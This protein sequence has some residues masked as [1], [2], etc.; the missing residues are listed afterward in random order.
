MKSFELI[1]SLAVFR[2]MTPAEILAHP[3]WRLPLTWQES[4]S[5]LR[6]DA[7]APAEAIWLNVRFEKEE[8]A[9]G[10]VPSPEFP[11]LSALFPI[12]DQVPQAIILAV[13]EKEV[14]PLFQA[15]ENTMRREFAVVGLREEGAPAEST[16]FR[17]TDGDGEDRASFALS[18]TPALV[19]DLGRLDFLDAGHDSI[20]AMRVKGEMVFAEFDLTDA[21]IAALKVGDHLLLPEL[22][23]DTPGAFCPDDQLRVDRVRVAAS[24]PVELAFADIVA[25]AEG[26][27]SAPVDDLT[28]AL[29]ARRIAS[30]RR[31]TLGEQP[32]LAIEEVL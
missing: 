11:D 29:G 9:L 6:S 13:I 32:A 28:L 30:G 31:V 8:C 14:G 15:L 4:E 27:R 19:A 16:A 26:M 5:F 17:V 1:E 22:A 7:V 23:E 2:R 20:A 21:E 3:A 24:K 18:F 25:G 10:L 12:R